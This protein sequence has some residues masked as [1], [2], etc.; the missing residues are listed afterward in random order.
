MLTLS[1]SFE[2]HPI[3]R[4]EKDSTIFNRLKR[5]SEGGLER[6]FPRALKMAVGEDIVAL[7]LRKQRLMSQCLFYGDI[8]KVKD[9]FTKYLTLVLC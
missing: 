7:K 8:D 6:G 3:W 9:A 4:G 5:V 2:Q 1:G